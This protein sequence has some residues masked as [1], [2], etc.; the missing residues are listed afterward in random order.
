MQ[1]GIS[2]MPTNCAENVAVN[3]GISKNFDRLKI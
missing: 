2:Y 3:S 1:L